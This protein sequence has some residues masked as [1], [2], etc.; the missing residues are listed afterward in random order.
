[1]EF[2]RRIVDLIRKSDDKVFIAEV[3]QF[4]NRFE[5]LT[6]QRITIAY[7]DADDG[8]AQKSTTLDYIQEGSPWHWENET[9]RCR[10]VVPEPEQEVLEQTPRAISPISIKGASVAITPGKNTQ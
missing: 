7:L 6:E 8:H 3:R 1:M 4:P 10:Y 5:D 2:N 9:F